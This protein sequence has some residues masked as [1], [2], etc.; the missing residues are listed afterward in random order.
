MRKLLIPALLLTTTTA[1]AAEYEIDPSHS[2]ASFSVK[3]LMVSNV[4]GAI[5]SAKGKVVYD[6]AHPENSSVEATIDPATI[7]TND[8]KRD[9]HLKSPDF[10]DV[11]ANP[12]ISFKSKRVTPTGPQQLKV[13]GDLTIHGVT[14][15]V[16]LDVDGPT[17]EIVDP[18]GNKKRGASAIT[19]INRKDFGLTWNK[20]LET[21]GVAVGEDVAITLDIEMTRK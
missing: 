21:G 10:L 7:N 11:P 19:K 13:L 20:V 1:F 8:Q 18:W 6:Q 5:S 4:R 9:A 2:M 12:L 16:T 17:E 14:K 3:H 15:E